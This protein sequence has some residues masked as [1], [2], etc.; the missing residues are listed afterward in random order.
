MERCSFC[1]TEIERG[2]GKIFVKKEGSL[3]YFCSNKCE[4]NLLKLGRNPVKFGWTRKYQK[5]KGRI[6]VAAEVRAKSEA[7]PKKEKGKPPKPENEAELVKTTENKE[8][9]KEAEEKKND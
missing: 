2:T 4:K 5:A 7:Q 1:G 8:E 9:K 3:L 6:D